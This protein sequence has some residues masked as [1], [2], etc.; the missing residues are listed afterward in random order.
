MGVGTWN[1]PPP[2]QEWTL[3]VAMGIFWSE[4]LGLMGFTLP[5]LL[6]FLFCLFVNQSWCAEGQQESRVRGRVPICRELPFLASLSVPPSEELEPDLGL[7]M[8]KVD[9]LAQL[10]GWLVGQG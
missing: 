6:G 2:R 8:G 9:S 1:P 10:L 4:S 5:L 7:T 3:K